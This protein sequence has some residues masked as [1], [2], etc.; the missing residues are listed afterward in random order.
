MSR[1]DAAPGSD[2]T[3]QSSAASG[4]DL[5][6]TLAG[7]RLAHPVLN[8]SGTF[9]ALETARRYGT[10]IVTPFP[11]AAYVPKTV[12]L[13][14]RAGNAPPR[15]TETAAGMINAVGLQNPG[16]EAWLA[17]FDLLADVPVPVVVNIGGSRPQD[18]LEVL[19]R[20]EDRLAAGGPR[21]ARIVGYEL[22][23]SC[24]NVGRG[25][26]AIGTEPAETARLT[27]AARQL[28]ERLVIVKLTP[29]VTD[30][31]AVARAAAEAGADAVSLVNTVRALVLDPQSLKPFLGNRTGGLSGPA[32]K[33][34]ALRMVWEVAAA[35]ELPIVGMGGI[36]S[37]RDVLEF[38]A[39]GA[40]AVA[41]G[42]ANFT[43]PEAAR[44][45]VAE[46]AAEMRDRGLDGLA[47]LRGRALG[48][49]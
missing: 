3:P 44:R 19:R 18:Y 9:D 14:P 20:V 48:D 42:A 8:A 28:T 47:A 17:D 5:A 21:A 30:V 6:V 32:I 43:G 10:E 37:G 39:C 15:L 4:P 2:A 7:V 25:G 11:F 1:P 13:E 34:I 49:L 12:T 45:I 24:P 22:N 26:L 36:A 35:L 33:P 46:L 23:V 38:I 27:A 40:T 41:V 16:I 29:N 31:V